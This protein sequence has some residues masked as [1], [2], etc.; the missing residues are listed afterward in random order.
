MPTTTT[1]AINVASN[2]KSHINQK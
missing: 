1:V 2:N